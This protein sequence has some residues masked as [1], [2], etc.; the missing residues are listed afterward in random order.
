MV[1]VKEKA[2]DGLV[3]LP[4][5]PAKLDKPAAAP[6]LD[7]PPAPAHRTDSPMVTEDSS[8]TDA[9]SFRETPRKWLEDELDVRRP[10]L[11]RPA[12]RLDVSQIRK[13]WNKGYFREAYINMS[14]FDTSQF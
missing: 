14:G 2:A 9:P 6:P 1:R 11:Y 8:D 4:P 3:S 5:L 12:S 10:Q 7:A 13:L